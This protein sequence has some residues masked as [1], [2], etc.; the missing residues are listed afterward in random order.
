MFYISKPRF[1]Q[2]SHILSVMLELKYSTYIDDE[3]DSEQKGRETF[4]PY[5]V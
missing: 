4:C 1:K 5:S 2:C 3:S